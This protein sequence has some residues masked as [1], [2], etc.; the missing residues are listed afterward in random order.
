MVDEA[1]SF[2]VFQARGTGAAARSGVAGRARRG[3][4]RSE[5][6]VGGL[7]ASLRGRS[8]HVDRHGP[9]RCRPRHATRSRAPSS[10]S[11]RSLAGRAWRYEHACHLA[12]RLPWW[13]RHQWRTAV[14]GTRMRCAVMVS[15]N[16]G[17]LWVMSSGS[18]PATNS[19]LTR[20]NAAARA[21]RDRASLVDRSSQRMRYPTS[22]KSSPE[23]RGHARPGTSRARSRARRACRTAGGASGGRGWWLG[24]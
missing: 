1:L 3:D 15:P 10:E 24:S 2:T 9:L 16:T 14:Q 5:G 23:R 20:P 12:E 18:W 13:P 11:L 8:A 17:G 4:A 6:A 7:R 19:R 21:P 22:R